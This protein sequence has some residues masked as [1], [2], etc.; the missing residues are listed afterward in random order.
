MGC[1]CM[2]GPSLIA[3]ITS[4]P[5][6]RARLRSKSYGIKLGLLCGQRIPS[7]D[8]TRL[9]TGHP[10][11][12]DFDSLPFRSFTTWYSV[13]HMSFGLTCFLFGD[14]QRD[15]LTNEQYSTHPLVCFSLVTIVIRSQ[16]LQPPKYFCPL[17]SSRSV[18]SWRSS[19]VDYEN[20]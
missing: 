6:I 13:T 18:T 20:P 12:L 8:V 14:V 5:A 11:L 16:I 10:D 15:T 3:K 17:L 19:I 7:K 4:S 1:L 9:G 2:K